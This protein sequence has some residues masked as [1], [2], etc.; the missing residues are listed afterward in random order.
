MKTYADTGLL[1]SLYLSETTSAAAVAVVRTG[2]E[3][4]PL[5]PL[6]FLELRNGLNLALYRQRITAA[7]RAAAWSKVQADI[8]GGLLVQTPVAAADLHAKAAELSDRHAATLGTRTL[9]ILHVAAALL[10]GAREFL[11]FDEKQRR[12][13]AAEGLKVRP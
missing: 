5:S 7:E 6:N 12:M 1:L 9:D 3:P 4:L 10:L 2:N 8:G 11:S 13:A